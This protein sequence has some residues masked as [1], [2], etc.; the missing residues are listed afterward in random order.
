MRNLYHSIDDYI[1]NK[2]QLQ[3][4]FSKV[5]VVIPQ[6]INAYTLNMQDNYIEKM[7]REYAEMLKMHTKKVS[8]PIKVPSEERAMFIDLIK[9]QLRA[10]QYLKSVAKIPV[11]SRLLSKIES[12]LL[13]YLDEPISIKKSTFKSVESAVSFLIDKELIKLEK[14]DHFDIGKD[15]V[16]KKYFVLT[17]ISLLTF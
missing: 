13:S 7:A 9:A 3:E 1:T 6:K 8:S 10:I 15:Y 11:K 14:L 2:K 4:D 16:D 5:F 12:E 17:L